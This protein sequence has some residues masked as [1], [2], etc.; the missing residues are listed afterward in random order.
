VDKVSLEIELEKVKLELEQKSMMLDVM[1][2]KM[3]EQNKKHA[4]ISG[5]SASGDSEK[6]K[7]LNAEI[8][9][10]GKQIEARDAALSSQTERISVLTN[11][12]NSANEALDAKSKQVRDL[13]KELAQINA[14]KRAKVKSGIDKRLSRKIGAEK[15][16]EEKEREITEYVSEISRLEKELKEIKG[17]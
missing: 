16:L 4:S 6:I 9:E 17:V 14:V 12:A 3:L 8:A 5:E 1:V 7:A 10:M 2:Q 11:K 15:A 13:Q